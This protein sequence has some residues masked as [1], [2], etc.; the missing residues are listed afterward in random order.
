MALTKDQILHAWKD[1]T[2]RDSL[3]PEDRDSLPD[4]P[5]A[6]DGSALTDEQL[7]QAAGGSTP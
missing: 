4:R 1:E 7:E 3:S 6:A 5:T 2:Y